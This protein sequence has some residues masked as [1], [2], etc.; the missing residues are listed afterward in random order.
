[1][2]SPERKRI[3]RR[4]EESTFVILCQG[5]ERLLSACALA[6]PVGLLSEGHHQ[7][8]SLKDQAMARAQ[9]KSRAEKDRPFSEGLSQAGVAPATV[10]VVMVTLRR[11]QRR[12]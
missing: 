10:A 3:L 2:L 7:R 11:L 5:R 12:T 6:R 8:L 4:E 1:M 9:R